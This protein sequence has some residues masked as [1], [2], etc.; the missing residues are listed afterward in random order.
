MHKG[1]LT[2]AS[3]T[4]EHKE[5]IDQIIDEGYFKETASAYNFFVSYALSLEIKITDNELEKRR[6]SNVDDADREKFQDIISAIKGLYIEERIRNL[7]PVRIMNALADTGIQIAIN[8]FWN[9]NSKELNME[10]LLG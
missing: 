2:K 9:K 8:K 7:I 5:F 3:I 4:Y 6:E 10:G 1:D